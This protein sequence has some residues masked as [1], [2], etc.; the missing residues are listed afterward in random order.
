[1]AAIAPH[2]FDRRE[3]VNSGLQFLDDLAESVA[4]EKDVVRTLKVGELPFLAAPLDL[5]GQ[6][7]GIDANALVEFI[8][9]DSRPIGLADAV[10]DRTEL[11]PYRQNLP[12]VPVE[13]FEAGNVFLARVVEDRMGGHRGDPFIRD[14]RRKRCSERR[15]SCPR[16]GTGKR[17][18][19]ENNLC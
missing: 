19:C 6:V 5:R 3:Q 15:R 4:D 18:V 13:E 1:M 7:G 11:K 12:E 8:L 16:A 9:P 17:R 14:R 10:S 2:Q